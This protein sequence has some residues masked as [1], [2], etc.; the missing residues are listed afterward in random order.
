MNKKALVILLGG[1]LALPMAAAASTLEQQ[2]V[3]SGHTVYADMS[4]FDENIAAIAGLAESRVVW[5]N[6]RTIMST[7]GEGFIYAVES[8]TRCSPLNGQNFTFRGYEL[9]FLDPNDQG[10]IV[11][12][13]TYRCPGGLL[14]PAQPVTDLLGLTGLNHVWVTATHARVFD[15]PITPGD[16][17]R[18]YNF[19]LAVDTSRMTTDEVEHSAEGGRTTSEINRGQSYCPE[20]DAAACTGGQDY[21][22]TTHNTAKVDLFFSRVDKG[23][24]AAVFG[25][26]GA[27]HPGTVAGCAADTH[28]AAVTDPSAVWSDP[29]SST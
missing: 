21:G 1:F 25:V 19:A 22:D 23:Q 17:G 27:S 2:N 13:Y 9:S 16:A 7:L 6:G 24:G 4:G 11:A 28:C 8:G 14:T 29:T 10:H 26:P 20:E 5:F 18:L 15:A 12:H 3:V